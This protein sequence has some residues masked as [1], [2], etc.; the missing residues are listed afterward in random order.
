MILPI[1]GEAMF[2]ITIPKCGTNCLRK[3]FRLLEHLEKSPNFGVRI[4]HLSEDFKHH[5]ESDNVKKIIL[6]RDL[7]DM[8]LSAIPFIQKEEGWL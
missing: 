6:V 2:V 3:Y 1:V 8:F 4:L 5:F 7:R